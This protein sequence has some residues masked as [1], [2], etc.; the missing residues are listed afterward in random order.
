MDDVIV[1]GGG[2]VGFVTA[3]GLARAGVRVRLIEA[4]DD[5]VRSP[6]AAVYHWSVL[7]GF[8]AL[9][10]LDDCRA[11]GF[12][13]QDYGYVIRA[14]GER[15]DYDLSVL[16]GRTEHPYNIHLGQDGM[17]EVVRRHLEAQSGVRIEFG[18]RFTGLAQDADGVTVRVESTEGARNLRCK[19][20]IGCDGSA[21]GVRKALG[22]GFDGI[23]WPER[24]VAT[25]TRHDFDRYGFARTTLRVDAE[26]G[27]VIVL[28][29]EDG[30]W[31]YTYKED[32]ALPEE[33]Y[34]ERMP[35]MFDE[36]LGGTADYEVVASAPYRMHQRSAERYRLGRVLLAGDAAHVTNPTGGLGLTGGLFDAY[37]LYPVLAAVLDGAD[38]S[39]LDHYDAE[40]RE[41][42]LTRTSPQASANKQLVFHACGGGQALEAAL[43]GLRRMRDDREY[44]FERLMFTKSLES[45]PLLGAVGV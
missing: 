18:C 42:F 17:T 44:R 30:L 23:T 33:T 35:R 40:R 15:I 31:R 25:N 13:K 27:A 32:A 5:V 36:L 43:A 8:A 29:T 19:W 11:A 37:A 28:L 6:R 2:P 26:F 22:L 10:I 41:I 21:S 7:D 14:T 45:A 1:I 34:R 12:A 9:G 39:V 4:G 20:V 3:L 38:A 24:F 16:E